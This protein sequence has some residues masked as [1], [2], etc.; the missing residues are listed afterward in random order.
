M[1]IAFF[2]LNT[3]A[4]VRVDSFQLTEA[5][6]EFAIITLDCT[7]DGVSTPIF[8]AGS[9]SSL[10]PVIVSPHDPLQLVP[11]GDH[12]PIQIRVQRPAGREE[13]STNNLTI[14]EMN[15]QQRSYKQLTSFAWS[16]AWPERLPAFDS[17]FDDSDPGAID[18]RLVRWNTQQ[19]H[20][21]KGQSMLAAWTQVL[22]GQFSHLGQDVLPKLDR[23]R[24]L[25]PTSPAL[26][27]ATAT[28][29]LS[30]AKRFRG[31]TNIKSQLD[32]FAVKL[33]LKY[34]QIAE[35][36]L[37]KSKPYASS[38]PTWYALYLELSIYAQKPEKFVDS[39]FFEGTR[40]YPNNMELYEKMAAFLTSDYPRV[41]WDKVENVARYAVTMSQSR[42]GASAYAVFYSRI[43][44]RQETGFE[45]FRDSLANWTTMKSGFED[46]YQRYP[47]AE[48]L[49]RYAAFACMAQ[50]GGTFLR[51]RLK[52]DKDV[53]PALWPSNHSFDLCEHAFSTEI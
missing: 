32:P 35:R 10:G 53:L 4:G 47:G 17:L 16:H 9:V 3:I 2:S 34:S 5:T 24:R 19:Q 41:E 6:P 49:N 37:V 1:L 42:E 46:M 8:V 51:L 11:K 38:I 27:L 31:D 22:E 48:T 7:N 30:Q 33:A 23:Q 40:K 29:W 14:F 15:P 25:H 43:A 26:A 13:L 12:L 21:S 18:A 39:L 45:P 44:E 36:V 20:D 28:F 50:D 52:I